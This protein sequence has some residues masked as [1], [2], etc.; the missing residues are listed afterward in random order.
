MIGQ[1][2]DSAA[3]QTEAARKTAAERMRRCRARRRAGY[4]CIVI[5]I[6]NDEISGLVRRGLLSADD[7]EELD[8]IQTAVYG[9]FERTIGRPS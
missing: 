6:S 1:T 3:V 8:A 4:R 2:T 7:R 5:E 9:F